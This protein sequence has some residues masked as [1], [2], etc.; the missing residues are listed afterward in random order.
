MIKTNRK[1]VLLH[2]NLGK[3]ICVFHHRTLLIMHYNNSK[4]NVR[5]LVTYIGFIDLQCTD[6]DGVM[7]RNATHFV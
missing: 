1:H 3:I 4:K 6:E 7:F 5:E 2:N